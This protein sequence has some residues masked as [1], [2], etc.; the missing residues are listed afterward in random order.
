MKNVTLAV[1]LLAVMS[2]AACTHGG[3]WTPQAAGR[4]AGEGQIEQVH[5]SS[6]DSAVSGG[7]RK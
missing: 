4:T 3:T 1:A 2:V 6:A 7:L 5:A